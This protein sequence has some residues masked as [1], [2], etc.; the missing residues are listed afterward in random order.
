MNTDVANNPAVLYVVLIITIL[1]A[2]AGAVPKILGP[3]STAY[4]NWNKRQRVAATEAD[5]ADIAEQ[6]RQ[7]AYLKGRMDEAHAE[8]SR[9]DA[10]I[11]EHLIWDFDM[12]DAAVKKGERP[13][14]P[15]PLIP[16]EPKGDS[17][18]QPQ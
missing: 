5:D 7:I 4:D 6:A 2:I 11:R 17:Q 10:L 18:P 14:H 13:R 3:V 1:I 15:P 16:T 9:R 12:Y 8:I